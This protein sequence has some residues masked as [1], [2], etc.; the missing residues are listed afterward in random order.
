[1]FWLIVFAVVLVLYAIAM[2]WPE[3]KPHPY[4]ASLERIPYFEWLNDF[5]DRVQEKLPTLSREQAM[6]AAQAS[7]PHMHEEDPIESA[8]VEMS[9]WD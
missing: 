5:A 3:R 7:W 6:A 2:Y 9:Y 4:S 8:D 1:M